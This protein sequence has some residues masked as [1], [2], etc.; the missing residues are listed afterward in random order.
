M[1]N[2]LY[3]DTFSQVR[4]ASQ[5]KM[6]VI[7]NYNTKSK[8]IRKPALVAAVIIATLILSVSVYAIISLLTPAEIAREFGEDL[9]AAAFED[10]RGISIQDSV[11]SHGHIFTLHGFAVGSNLSAYRDYTRIESDKSYF[12]ISIRRADGTALD[13]TEGYAGKYASNILFQGYKPWMVNAITLEGAIG[14]AFEKDGVIYIVYEC[15]EN[16]EM[17]ADDE[18][19]FAMWEQNGVGF[20]PGPEI[21]TMHEDG[22]ITFTEGAEFG[23]AMWTLPIDPNRADP[24]LVAKTLDELG[25]AM[26]DA[27]IN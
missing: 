13:I 24:D 17:F 18:I 2:K 10:G 22:S 7:M 15:G 21:F 3:K 8:T 26:E 16:I 20:S 9:L 5:N 27:C 11:T 6:E 25:I 23:H 1:K 14:S 4:S 12:V 19:Y